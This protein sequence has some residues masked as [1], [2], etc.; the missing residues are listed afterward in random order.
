MSHDEK[1]TSAEQVLKELGLSP[2]E[3]QAYLALVGRPPTSA[4]EIAIHIK[5]KPNDAQII[6]EKLVSM[7]L[8]KMVPGLT[9]RYQSIPPYTALLRQLDEFRGLI[10]S[11]KDKVPQNLA[12]QFEQ[13]VSSIG[14][15]T[16]LEDFL[17]YM[18][19]IKD[20][21][22]QALINQF[23]RF[24]NEFKKFNQLDAFKNFVNKIKSET[25]QQL[26]DRFEDIEQRF[27]SISGLSDFKTYAKSLKESVPAHLLDQFLQIE[28]QTRKVSGLDEL[29][30]F[31]QDSKTEIPRHMLDR[32]NAI[33][34]EFRKISGIDEL[35]E[36]VKTVKQTI[37]PR[38]S[39]QF[40]NIETEVKK[41]SG[42]DDLTRYVTG[43]AD[44]VPRKLM[45]EYAQLESKFRQ[46]SQLGQFRTYISTLK[47]NVPQELATQFRKFQQEIEKVREKI[48]VT[49]KEQFQEWLKI[50]D[51]V[52]GQFIN[53]FIEEIAIGELDKLRGVFEH[54]VIEGVS[55]ILTKVEQQVLEASKGVENE[56]ENFGNWLGE[57][58][59]PGFKKALGDVETGAVNVTSAIQQGVERLGSWFSQE[60]IQNLDM[61]LSDIE[62]GADHLSISIEDGLHHLK[63]W[64]SADVIQGF[65]TALS[66]VEQ[67]ASY[68]FETVEKG[69]ENL[70]SWFKKDVVEDISKTLA[71]IE[72]SADS[73][74]T[75]ITSE[76]G[77]MRS[78][79]NEDLIQSVTAILDQV[80]G[81]IGDASKAVTTDFFNLRTQLEKD[82]VKT[83]KE[84]LA[85]VEDKVGSASTLITDSINRLRSTYT[86]R[87]VTATKEMLTDVDIRLSRSQE[88]MYSLWEQAKSLVSYRFKDVW[89]VIGK[90]GTMAQINETVT[91]AKARLLLVAPE[92]EDIDPVPI[93]ELKPQVAVRIAANIDPKSPKCQDI[94][95]QLSQRPNIEIRKYDRKNIWG[96]SRESEE[97]LVSAVSSQGD[98]AGIAT[99][100]GEHQK[101]FIPILEDCWLQGKK[102]I[103]SELP[104]KP[105]IPSPAIKPETTLKASVPQRT[106]AAPKPS[107]LQPKPVVKIPVEPSRPSVSKEDLN[108]LF[109][110]VKSILKNGTTQQIIE[111]LNSL[112][113]KISQKF[114]W[115][116]VLYEI[117][118]TLRRLKNLTTLMTRTEFEEILVKVEDWQARL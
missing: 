19:M 60:V 102:F 21:V 26:S 2:L 48:F 97:T 107:T 92:I 59:V 108:P 46:A 25:P 88:T 111:S 90:E 44:S 76:F 62:K 24:E 42:V 84:T 14:E 100:V 64:F 43:L 93:L 109:A 57:N 13:F 103:A 105:S 73:A 29:M 79:F 34:N 115:H 47:S 52:F 22:P 99:V 20:E 9:P 55:N 101:M 51:D 3:V 40:K 75:I 82:V 67:G 18:R 80:E 41:I 27:R 49:S 96:I 36:F 116:V 106:E 5:S 95:S 6:A 12:D 39:A 56:F 16:G 71:D 65:T 104:L 74:A 83:T 7:G 118:A 85:K 8:F 72:T 1:T 70:Q 91:G 50:M 17:K 114:A 112:K 63:D 37:P 45:T 32:F 15:V 61:T 11:M 58:V 94:L 113:E 53:A 117:D 54:E 68:A 35:R 81:K 28:T 98:V 78:W 23:I 31:I 89:F 86:D 10:A 110:P 38:L 30:R 77:K 69:F 66:E 4:G 87:V 33:E